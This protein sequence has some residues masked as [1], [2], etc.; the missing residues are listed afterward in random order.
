LK[1]KQLIGPRSNRIGVFGPYPSGG[2]EILD[3]IAKMVSSLGFSA[4]AGF[5][6][7]L[8]NDPDDIHKLEGI[9]P[10]SIRAIFRAKM[11]SLG[12]D[13]IPEYLFYKVI[14]RLVWKA[15]FFMNESRG[16]IPELFGCAEERIPSMGFIMADEISRAEAN[17]PYLFLN[18][19][20]AECTVPDKILCAGDAINQPFCPFYH[21]VNIPWLFKEIFLR[22]GNRLIATTELENLRPLL[23]EWL[24]R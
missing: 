23:Q 10:K 18:S 24:P 22:E 4:I 14:P 6:Y 20:Y 1:A 9:S 5:G 21:S 16:Q 7:Y 8:P 2:R 17:C 19:T 3:Q 15:I 12:G 11:S 13:T